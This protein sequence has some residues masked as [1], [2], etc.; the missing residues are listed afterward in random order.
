MRISLSEHYSVSLYKKSDEE[1]DERLYLTEEVFD[2]IEPRKRKMFKKNIFPYSIS[3]QAIENCYVL[4]A[5]YYI[6]LEWLVEGKKYLHVEPKVNR[7]LLSIFQE[8]FSKEIDENNDRDEANDKESIEKEWKDGTSVNVDYIKMLLDIYSSNISSNEIGNLIKIDWESTPIKIEQKND[9]LTPFLVVQFLN[10]LKSIVRKGLKKSYYKVQENL[11]NKVRGKVLV[12]THIKQNI[13][14]NRLTQNYCEYQVFGEDN[15]ENKFLK[16]VLSYAIQ[17]IN[18][19]DFFTEESKNQ[20]NHIINYCRPAFEHISDDLKENQLKHFKSNPFFKEYKEAINIGNCI[21]RQ[22]AYNISSVTKNEVEIAPF[23][24]DMPRLFELYVYQKLLKANNFDTSKVCYQ[25]STY[26]NSLDFLIK[27]GENSMIIDTKY[28]L[29]YKHGHIHQDIRQVAGYSRLKSVRQALTID[30]QNDRNINCLIIY[31]TLENKETDFKLDS[32]LESF[33]L[34]EN[35]IQT[36]HKVYK[37]GIQL[38]V[39]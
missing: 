24:I 7:K 33:D 9:Q 31:P 19:C 17:Y 29:H 11:T 5:D 15:P 28:K 23:W 3:H 21:L 10:V 20:I 39:I 26:G 16:K 2:A 34:K 13:F 36:Y 25:F 37:L 14:K 22:F 38:P 32:I 12:G 8:S 27:N 4:K 18:N 30:E 6:G 35:Q 1:I